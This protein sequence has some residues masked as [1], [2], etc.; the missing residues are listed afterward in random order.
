MIPSYLL[1]AVGKRTHP[2]VGL[3]QDKPILNKENVLNVCHYFEPP[4]FL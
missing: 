2:L 4:T 3:I 1:A